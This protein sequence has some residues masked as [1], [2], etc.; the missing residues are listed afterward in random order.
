MARREETPPHVPGSGIVDDPCDW[1]A[2]RIADAVRSRR[3]TAAAVIE[4]HRRRAQ[5][6]ADLGAI[7][8]PNWEDAHRRAEHIDHRIAACEPVGALAGVPFTVK[9]VIA[10][11]GLP[12]TTGSRALRANRP[13]HQ[14]TAVTRLIAAGAILVGK[15]NCPEFAFGTTCDSPLFGATANP[16]DAGRSPGGSSGGEAAGIAAGIAALGIGSD[17]GGSLRW[18]AQCTGILALRPT[19][20][21]VPATGQLPGAGGELGNSAPALPSPSSLQGRLQVIGP[22]AR[23]V[24]DLSLALRIAA[25]PDGFDPAAAPVPLTPSESYEVR[26]LKIGW[27][28]GTHLGPVRREVAAL[29]TRTAGL[30]ADDGHAVRAVPDV[31]AGCVTAYNRLRDQDPLTDHLL[32]IAGREH[33]VLP[34]SLQVLRTS[35]QADPDA[36]TR[37]WRDALTTRA[38]ALQVFNEVDVV[39]LPIAAGPACLPDGS[40]DVDGVRVEGWELMNHCRAVSLLGA[41]AVSVPIGVSADGLPLSVQVVAAPWQEGVALAVAERLIGIAPG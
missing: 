18:P 8:S 15:T 9:D 11:A 20:G 41:P 16:L 3:I 37:A 39:L 31:F 27:S 2:H 6:W 38:H 19:P 10:V 34:N 7:V 13:V 25:G 24:A 30:L 40:L 12:A 4:A 32:A 22:L 29:I 17:F 1:P 21:R 33:E 35:A 5:D 36:R 23:N 28:D 14:A 26:E